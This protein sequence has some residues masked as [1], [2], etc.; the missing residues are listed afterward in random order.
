V[1]ADEQL[2]L[3]AGQLANG[4]SVPDFL[5]KRFGHG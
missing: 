4:V 1:R 5:K 3:T 2:S